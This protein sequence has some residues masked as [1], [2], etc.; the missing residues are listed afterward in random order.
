MFVRTLH[1]PLLCP[2]R[3][4][5]NPASLARRPRCS[6]VTPAPAGGPCFSLRSGSRPAPGRRIDEGALFSTLGSRLRGNDEMMRYS[7]ATVGN[8]KNLYAS[9]FPRRR[10]PSGVR[11]FVYQATTLDSRFRGN[12]EMKRY[13]DATVGMLRTFTFRRSRAGGNPVAFVL[14][15]TKQPHWIPAFAEMTKFRMG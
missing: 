5:G 6:L 2:S 1:H 12:D 13:S 14:S 9:S 3:A 7:D 11:P 15:C 8:V 4:R 10:E